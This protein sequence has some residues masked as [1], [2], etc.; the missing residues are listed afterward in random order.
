M[1]TMRVSG[2]GHGFPLG[3]VGQ[4][5][6]GRES[7]TSPHQGKMRDIV[8]R[9]GNCRDGVQVVEAEDVQNVVLSEGVGDYEGC[10]VVTVWVNC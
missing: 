10:W 5:V 8:T 7:E 6:V 2:V 1:I 9:V 4:E 3:V